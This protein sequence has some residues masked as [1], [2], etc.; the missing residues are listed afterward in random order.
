MLK[1]EIL[2]NSILAKLWQQFVALF[3]IFNITMPLCTKPTIFFPPVF[4]QKN[5]TG[6]HKALTST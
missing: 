3:F 1:H 5:L 2:E 4:V 6:L